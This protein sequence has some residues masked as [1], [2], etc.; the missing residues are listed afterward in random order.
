[1]QADKC[2][3]MQIG[4]DGKARAVRFQLDG[5]QFVDQNDY[6]INYVGGYRAPAP[7][8]LGTAP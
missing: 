1:M 3:L 8:A 4:P 2:C 5:S 7:G 6:Y